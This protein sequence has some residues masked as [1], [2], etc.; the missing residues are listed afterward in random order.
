[1]QAWLK[2]QISGYKMPKRFVILD[3]MPKSAY[4]KIT[5]KMIRETLEQR[6]LLNAQA[7]A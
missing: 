2:P 3:E 5:K 1:M 4:G 7:D 6:G